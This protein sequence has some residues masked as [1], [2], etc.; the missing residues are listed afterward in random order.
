MRV[1]IAPGVLRMLFEPGRLG[2]P[3]GYGCPSCESAE[4]GSGCP[5]PARRRRQLALPP[6]GAAGVRRHVRQPLMECK[7]LAEK[8]LS[9]N[10]QLIALRGRGLPARR[11]TRQV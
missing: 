4:V 2:A 1:Q 9:L 11:E 8:R 3:V 5:F 6:H 7:Q 10:G